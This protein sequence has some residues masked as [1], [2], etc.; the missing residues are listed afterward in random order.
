MPVMQLQE[1]G[2][3]ERESKFNAF[4]DFMVPKIAKANLE[5]N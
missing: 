3:Y 2:S 5:I 1:N 4:T